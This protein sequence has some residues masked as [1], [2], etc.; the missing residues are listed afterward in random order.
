MAD[1]SAIYLS[2]R[3]P[4]A[5]AVTARGKVSIHQ[6]PPPR[7]ASL[8][9]PLWDISARGFRALTDARLVKF[10]LINRPAAILP[11]ALPRSL[12]EKGAR[13]SRLNY[14]LVGIK[15]NGTRPANTCTIGAFGSAEAGS[16][17]EGGGRQRRWQT[18]R[19]R[20]CGRQCPGP[21]RSALVRH[22][23]IVHRGC[24]GCT[25]GWFNGDG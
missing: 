7:A 4:D 23:E 20:F 9:Y 11:A 19:T 21:P 1:R 13:D 3:S 22:A 16:E 12:P 10:D 14:E 24:A 8:F 18:D 15:A 2:S 25:R 17:G 5:L 6:E